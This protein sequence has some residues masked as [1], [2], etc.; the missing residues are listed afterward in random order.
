[1]DTESELAKIV[2][3]PTQI[4]GLLCLMLRTILC[5]ILHRAGDAFNLQA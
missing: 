2:V 5:N 3:E 1:M 4:K